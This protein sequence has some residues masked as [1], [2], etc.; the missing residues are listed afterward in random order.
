MKINI[1]ENIRIMRKE[2]KL[3][4]EQLAEAMGVTV[5]AVSKWESALSIPDVGTILE[6]AGFFETSVDVLLGYERQRSSRERVQGELRALRRKKDFDTGV[7][8]AEKALMKYPNCFDIVYES[9]ILFALAGVEKDSE[10]LYK[11]SLELHQ[12]SLELLSQNTNPN[13]GEI[14]IKQDMAHLYMSINRTDEALELLK[15]ANYGGIN[16]VAIGYALAVMAKKPDEALT[17]LSDAFIELAFNQLSRFAVAYSTA[18]SN[19]DR[20]EEAIQALQWYAGLLRELRLSDAVTYLDRM[21]ATS[22]SSIALLAME[23]GDE[24]RARCALQRTVMLAR[25]FDAKPCYTLEGVR[26]FHGAGTETAYDDLGETTM[27]GLYRK[28]TENPSSAERMKALWAEIVKEGAE[29][30]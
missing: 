26:F 22:M 1:S 15:K 16:N 13:I 9:A 24:E 17:Y 29:E 11:R 8:E 7:R 27:E 4:Q 23:Q 12:Q 21:E 19:L 25:R 30:L 3:T 2:R 10:K 18:C 28:I 20:N 5:G 6:L 14:S